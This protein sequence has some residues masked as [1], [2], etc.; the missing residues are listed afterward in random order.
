M[1]PGSTPGQYQYPG[2]PQYHPYPYQPYVVTYQ[3]PPAQYQLYPAQYQQLQPLYQQQ[4]Y[5]ATP[6]PL[7]TQ[8]IKI[9]PG[10]SN[11]TNK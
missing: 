5:S 2:P 11:S 6:Q 8:Q 3:Q 1:W 7:L 10:G 9:E 4:I